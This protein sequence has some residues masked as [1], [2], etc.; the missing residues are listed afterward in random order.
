MLITVSRKPLDKGHN[1]VQN[2]LKHG[3]GALNIDGSRIPY[4]GEGD[5]CKP[6]KGG[7]SVYR[8]YMDGSGQDYH[9]EHHK[10]TQN[11]AVPNPTGRWPA[12]VILIPSETVLDHFPDVKGQVGMSKTVGGHRFMAGG[13][14][15]IQ[16]FDYGKTDTGSASR[17][18]KNI[19]E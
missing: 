4:A 12:N 19:K 14:E 15:T 2:V 1:V 11:T 6:S 17:F 8:A 13:L 18:F 10:P 5:Q 9:K 7:G 3:C 16:K